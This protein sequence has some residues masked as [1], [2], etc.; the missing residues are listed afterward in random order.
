MTRADDGHRDRD[1]RGFNAENFLRNELLLDGTAMCVPMA[2]VD[3]VISRE[4][5]AG[6]V[7][8]RQ[9]LALHTIRSLLDD[10]LMKIGD[11]RGAS[12]ESVVPW[13]LTIDAAMERIRD[14]FV[15][16]YHERTLWDLTIWLQLTR[17]GERFARALKDESAE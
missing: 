11:I 15:D 16:H 10:G 1:E 2:H 13:N 7:V 17:A 8:A 6:D 12:D 9:Q 5:L 14:L 4:H 3:S